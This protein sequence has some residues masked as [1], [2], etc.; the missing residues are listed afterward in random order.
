[1]NKSWSSNGPFGQ[2][3]NAWGYIFCIGLEEL[4]KAGKPIVVI[5]PGKEW[6]QLTGSNEGIPSLPGRSDWLQK[7]YFFKVDMGQFTFIEKPC[8]AMKICQDL[9]GSLIHKGLF[10]KRLFFKFPYPCQVLWWLII[11]GNTSNIGKFPNSP[12]CRGHLKSSQNQ[13]ESFKFLKT[14]TLNDIAE[15]HWC[16]SKK[17]LQAF[18]AKDKTRKREC[19][20]DVAFTLGPVYIRDSRTRSSRF[21]I[22]ERRE[23]IG[24]TES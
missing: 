6:M 8:W 7:K 10:G 12:D 2:V 4:R 1:M 3:D 17:L 16:G 19:Y 20:L 22:G 5:L 13:N 11:L 18:T 9:I 21:Q 14:E 24:Y 23:I 15:L